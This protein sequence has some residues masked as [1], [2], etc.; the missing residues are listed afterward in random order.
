MWLF[1][2]EEKADIAARD[3]RIVERT[4]R[5]RTAPIKLLLPYK[6]KYKCTTNCSRP[7]LQ[8]D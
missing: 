4:E 7:Q 3:R 1:L 6:Y 2:A 8:L 5:P